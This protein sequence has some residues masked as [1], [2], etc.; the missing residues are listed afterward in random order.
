VA[1]GA[2]LRTAPRHAVLSNRYIRSGHWTESPDIETGTH[3]CDAD[4]TNRSR[5]SGST[6]LA[7]VEAVANEAASWLM[8]SSVSNTV[9]RSRGPNAESFG[10]TRLPRCSSLP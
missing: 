1:P 8:T 2:P 4:V 3:A 7:D 6:T 10:G 9:R 5:R